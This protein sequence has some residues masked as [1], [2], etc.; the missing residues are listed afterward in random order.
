MALNSLF[1]LDPTKFALGKGSST[2]RAVRET[3]NKG[4][5][6]S[7]DLAGLL[8]DIARPEAFTAEKPVIPSD[9]PVV[10]PLGEETRKGIAATRAAMDAVV[11][12]YTNISLQG[13]T[14]PDVTRARQRAEAELGRGPQYYQD[15]LNK[16][17]KN[18]ANKSDIERLLNLST[19]YANAR[20]KGN[21]FLQDVNAYNKQVDAYKTAF[22][23][24]QLAID[25]YNKLAKEH[26][27]EIATF[28]KERNKVVDKAM[29]DYFSTAT[30]DESDP[31]FAIQNTGDQLG[32]TTLYAD[33][34]H[35]QMLERI[36][37]VN[38]R[39]QEASGNGPILPYTPPPKGAK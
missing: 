29:G 1:D 15:I 22:A 11:A 5:A 12:Q 2:F 7:I 17:G 4:F 14:N 3:G 25:E 9:L 8:S 32:G 16:Y 20:A 30:V 18:L 38:L 10:T 26:Q 28:S 13:V 34:L 6:G 23:P 37:E 33:D 24:T 21:P 19:Q 36:A 35:N 39:E 27:K 31:A